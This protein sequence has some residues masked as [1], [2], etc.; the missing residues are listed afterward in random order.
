MT[1]RQI[2][3]LVSTSHS[4]DL[5]LTAPLCLSITGNEALARD[6]RPNRPRKPNVKNVVKAVQSCGLH[7]AAVKIAPDGTITVEVGKGE[8]MQAQEITPLDAWMAKH[9]RSA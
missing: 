6:S 1:A 2:N 9:A 5:S 8:G 4:S 3:Q 7:V